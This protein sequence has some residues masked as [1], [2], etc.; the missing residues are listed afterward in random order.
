[1]YLEYIEHSGSLASSLPVSPLLTLLLQ[2][3]NPPTLLIR[4]NWKKEGLLLNYYTSYGIL[5]KKFLEKL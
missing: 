1:M 2:P 3:L 5:E 4:T